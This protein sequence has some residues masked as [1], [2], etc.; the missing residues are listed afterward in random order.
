MLLNPEP[1]MPLDEARRLANSVIA[2][3]S[4]A[5]LGARAV[6]ALTDYIEVL[7]LRLA[8]PLPTH[9][10]LRERWAPLGPPPPVERIEVQR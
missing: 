7:E 2:T 6:R 8:T 4:V 3:G 10:E 5:M 1:P 9:A